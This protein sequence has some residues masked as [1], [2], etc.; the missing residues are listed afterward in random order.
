MKQLLFFL[1]LLCCAICSTAQTL[2]DV[3]KI[4]VKKDIP[5]SDGLVYKWTVVPGNDTA[6]YFN[7]GVDTYE[8]IVT[9]RKVGGS[10]PDTTSK[11]IDGQLANYLPLGA[12]RLGNTTTPGWYLNTTAYTST[13]NATAT[14]DFNGM[15][16]ELWGETKS[17]HGTAM[18]SI[19]N[20][21]EVPV[22]FKSNTTV[23]PAL[24]WK[25]PIL[26]RMIHTF[27]LRVVSGNSLIDYFIVR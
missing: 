12:W 20:G 13:A 5:L 25:S 21:P 24:I 6:R 1:L 27:R 15:Q 17:N 18:V 3:S 9:F 16:I 7:P 22:S 8:A 14:I 26:P 2:V 10:P 11:K 19:D 4:Y 23:L